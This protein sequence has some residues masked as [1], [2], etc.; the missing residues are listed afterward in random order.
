MPAV[1]TA[2]RGIQ[3]RKNGGAYGGPY[4]Q[5]NLIEHGNVTL[6]VA[7]GDTDNEVDIT[8]A[9]TGLLA[10][11]HVPLVSLAVAQAI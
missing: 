4:E 7:D 1:R 3:V 8:I 10:E 11:I 9:A 2:A 6:T 5:L